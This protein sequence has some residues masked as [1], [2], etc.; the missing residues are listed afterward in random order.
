MDG[1]LYRTETIL[2][3]QEIEIRPGINLLRVHQESN[4]TQRIVIGQ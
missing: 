3:K 1:G 2:G 4:V